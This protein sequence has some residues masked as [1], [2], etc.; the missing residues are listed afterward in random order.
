MFMPIKGTDKWAFIALG[1]NCQG[2]MQQIQTK[3]RHRENIRYDMRSNEKSDLNIR[4]IAEYVAKRLQ[5]DNQ[6]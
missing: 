6:S 5:K 2:Q 1:T 3:V 4:P